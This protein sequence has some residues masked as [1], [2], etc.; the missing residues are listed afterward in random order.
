ME[1][2]NDTAVQTV[3]LTAAAIG[4]LA[5][6]AYDLYREKSGRSST[7]MTREQIEQVAQVVAS[8]VGRVVSEQLAAHGEREESQMERLLTIEGHEA[9]RAARVETTLAR[10]TT[11]AELG[12]QSSAEQQRSLS[13]RLDAIER[14]LASRIELLERSVIH[15][16]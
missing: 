15:H 4:V 11:I 7:L 2:S 13:A 9:D 3:A 10:L 16:N 8:A 6:L 5:R 14:S 1:I 12:A